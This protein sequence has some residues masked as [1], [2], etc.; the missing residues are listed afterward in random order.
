MAE[1]CEKCKS[2][3]NAPSRR[4]ARENAQS[5]AENLS[6]IVDKLGKKPNFLK[7]CEKCRNP[8]QGD[9]KTGNQAGKQPN[10]TKSVTEVP[11]ERLPLWG[12][13]SSGWTGAK[14]QLKSDRLDGRE[15]MIPEDYRDVVTNYFEALA[16]EA[17]ES[18]PAQ[19]N[20]VPQ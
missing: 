16:N 8:G 14:R 4:E 10:G 6:Q 19:E 17:S 5:A 2:A 12:G 20:K 9:G 15:S 18:Q 1:A 11:F 7:N 3:A 13:A